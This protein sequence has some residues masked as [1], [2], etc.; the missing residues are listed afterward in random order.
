[1]KLLLNL[2]GI[3][4]LMSSSIIL[5]MWI[6][7]LYGQ[8][9]QDASFLYRDNE[10]W[11]GIELNGV[12]ARFHISGRD[13]V[14]KNV[15]LLNVH[16]TGS[17]RP[18]MFGGNLALTIPYPLKDV[19]QEGICEGIEEGQIITYWDKEDYSYI[20]H[21]VIDNTIGDGQ[22]RVKGDNNPSSEYPKC[23]QIRNIIIGVL[24]T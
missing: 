12:K 16:S 15:S 9:S 3:V 5:G 21:R 17:M 23:S 4:L 1:M 6:E 22:L 20:S 13:L 10:T 11:Q 18:T 2:I 8:T 14:V 7:S 19:E 24:Y